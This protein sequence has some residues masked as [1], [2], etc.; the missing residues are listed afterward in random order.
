MAQSPEY[1]E[2]LWV[3]P[4]SYTS[5]RKS[6]Q[7]TVIVIHTT[8]GS[9]GPNSAEDGAAYDQRRTDG[10]S[11]HF[12]VDSNSIVQCVR[13]TDEAHTA[14]QTG[15]DI[16]IHLELCG[17]AGQSSSQWADP[18]SAATVENAAEVCRRLR[19]KYPFPIVRLSPSQLRSGARGFCGHVDIS[20][21]FGE[22]DHT[23]PGPNFPW[24]R[25]FDLIEEEPMDRAEFIGHFAAALEDQTVQA[26]LR[27]EVVSYMMTSD[28][29]YN[30]LSLY[31]MLK[32]KVPNIETQVAQLAAALTA[33]EG[34]TDL[35][36]IQN[37]LNEQQ[38]EIESEVRDA[39]ADLGE[40]GSVKVRGPQD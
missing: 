39:V 13:T 36:A 38:E 2:Y 26:R 40:G 25:L 18:V 37:M 8:E 34:D 33:A 22:S 21:A 16:G 32:A 31:T 30:L 23:D 29:A 1:P 35:V 3:P 17:K 15:N 4:K 7:P 12:Y 19:Q 28:P 11:A 10:T 9:E 27:R 6:G 20:N 24:A 5:G 14:R